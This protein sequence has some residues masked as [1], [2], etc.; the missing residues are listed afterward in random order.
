MANN[1][2]IAH[3]ESILTLSKDKQKLLLLISKVE[4]KCCP[5]DIISIIKKSEYANF[6]LNMG[7][8]HEAIQYSHAQ[9]I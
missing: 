6:K 9:S 3:P 5:D 8:I 2:I 4:E 1:Q 7:G